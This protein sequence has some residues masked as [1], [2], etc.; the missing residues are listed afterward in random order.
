MS[1]RKI[2]KPVHSRDFHGVMMIFVLMHFPK[3]E[4]GFDSFLTWG[5]KLQGI[6]HCVAIC[7]DGR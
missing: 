1:R 5:R 3:Q 2:K 4:H 6:F 7:R